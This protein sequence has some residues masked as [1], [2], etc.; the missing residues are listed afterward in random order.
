M[1]KD[2]GG[3][4]LRTVIILW[5]LAA[6][7]CLL[8][9]NALVV[10]FQTAM[11]ALKEGIH[12]E[13][14]TTPLEAMMYRLIRILFFDIKIILSTVLAW[15]ILCYFIKSVNTT[16]NNVVMSITA[17]Y[18][19]VAVMFFYFSTTKLG[20]AIIADEGVMTYFGLLVPRLIF[21]KL[22]PREII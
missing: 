19:A 13:E 11:I 10:T 8:L 3:L 15:G 9:F 20:K 5:L 4:R 7:A 1:S 17:I 2:Q 21:N 16:W 14:M 18:I 12:S 6:V 22:K